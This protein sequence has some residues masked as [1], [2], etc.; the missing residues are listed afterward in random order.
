MGEVADIVIQAYKGGFLWFFN[1][2]SLSAT[3]W[4]INY[5]WALT[6]ISLLVFILELL[7]PWRKDQ[8]AFREDFFLDLF[9]MYFNFFIFKLLFFS[10]VTALAKEAVSG[11][12]GGS[13]SILSLIHAEKLPYI[14]QVIIFF[15]ILDF[16]QW[17]THLGL[18]RFRILWTF[19]KVHHSVRVMGFA[20]HLRYHWMETVIYTPVKYFA[21]LLIGG[22]EPAN[23]FILYYLSILI[24]HLNHSNIRL[25]YGPLK[26][27]LN[28]P[29]M[30]IW[31]HAETLPKRYRYGANFGI[32]LSLWDFLFKT[33]YIDKDGRDIELGFKK[34][35]RF[36]KRFGGQVIYPIGRRD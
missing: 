20:A 4:Y 1:E 21:I 3:P 34:L 12:T 11:L 19:H 17:L 16:A 23:V 13:P 32:S 10:P 6:I 18:H 30:H 31:H 35:D 25:T 28:N 14:L 7:F 15:L 22:F 8:P 5:F 29:V 26:Y 9:Y 27:L 33:A 36:P 24:G 2:I